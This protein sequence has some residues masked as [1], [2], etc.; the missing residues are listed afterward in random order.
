[1][2]SSTNREQPLALSGDCDKQIDFSKMHHS[3]QEYYLKLEE[4]KNAH[5]ETMAKLESMY[6]NKLHLKREQPLG[7]KNAAAGVCCR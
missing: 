7:K 3:N 4:L 2:D 1:M 5:L 6:R